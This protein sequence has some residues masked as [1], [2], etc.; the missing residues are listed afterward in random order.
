VV[1]FFAL[2]F[3]FCL[4]GFVMIHHLLRIDLN[5]RQNKELVSTNN[6]QFASAFWAMNFD[7][8]QLI[9]IGGDFQLLKK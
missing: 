7:L 1:Q 3:D 9:K 8:F 5:S 4:F 6:L 2:N